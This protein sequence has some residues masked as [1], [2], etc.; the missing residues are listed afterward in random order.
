MDELESFSACPS[1]ERTSEAEIEQ[2][3]GSHHPAP[4]QSDWTR[5]GDGLQEERRGVA[6]RVLLL[7][8]VVFSLDVVHKKFCAMEGFA[9]DQ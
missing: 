3:L 4:P 2:R 5:Q 9:F 7:M 1:L 6:Q 8:V